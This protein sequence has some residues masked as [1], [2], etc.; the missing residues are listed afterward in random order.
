MVRGQGRHIDDI[1][2]VGAR[3]SGDPGFGRGRHAS[4]NRRAS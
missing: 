1:N 3:L 4:R 2:R